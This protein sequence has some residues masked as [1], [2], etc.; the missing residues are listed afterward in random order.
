[1]LGDI[2]DYNLHVLFVGINPDPES[3]RRNLYYI[4]RSN[5]FW[6]CLNESGL[7]YRKYTADQAIELPSDC[8]IGITN[9]C[10]RPT[11]RASKLTKEEKKAGVE[12]L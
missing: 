7:V 1:M 11:A 4:G 3:F 8:G 6:Y 12:T 2:I 9:L 5:H 10:H